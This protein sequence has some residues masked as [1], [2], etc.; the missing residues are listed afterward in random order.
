MKV[1]RGEGAF[2]DFLKTDERVTLPA[3][4]LEALFDLGY[5][6]KNVDVV[7]ARVFRE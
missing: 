4:K 5:H 3:D 1:W 6:T 7:F 2:L